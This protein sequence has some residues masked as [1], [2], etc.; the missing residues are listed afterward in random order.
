M[1]IGGDTSVTGQVGN[2]DSCGDNQDDRYDD[3]QFDLNEKPFLFAHALNSPFCP[4]I[5]PSKCIW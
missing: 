3:Q 2:G 5:C 4:E 1:F